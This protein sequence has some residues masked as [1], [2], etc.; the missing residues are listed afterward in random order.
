MLNIIDQELSERTSDPF[1]QELQYH[2]DF[3]AERLKLFMG[4]ADELAKVKE[5]SLSALAPNGGLPLIVHGP[6][7]IGK[8]AFMAKVTA[9]IKGSQPDAEVIQRFIGAS[10]QSSSL[11]SFLGDLLREIARRYEQAEALPEGGLKE[12]I[13]ELPKRLSWATADKPLLLVIDALDQFEATI[14]EAR[15]HEWLPKTIPAHVA[16]VL[17]VLDG[18]I[19]NA[20][21]SRYPEA[22]TLA[23]PP[24]GREDGREI[25]DALLFAGDLVASERKRKLTDNQ[26]AVVLKAFEQNGRPLF[27]S[28]AAGIVRRWKSWERPEPLP[29]TIEGLVECIVKTSV[30]G[31]GKSWRI[32]RSITSLHPVLAY[33]TEILGLLWA[34]AE[35][36]ETN[37]K[38][39]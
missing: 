13:E 8:S 36:H 30:T 28:L 7:G 26:Y 31:M 22:D 20:A 15:H 5:W 11:Q 38:K 14:F 1:D 34:D 18:E 12:L 2:R 6:G 19:A 37:S 35:A 39:R 4:R 29:N 17:S 25:L 16:V 33:R 9:E 21:I 10:P 24:L 27:L 23:P 32:A 3:S